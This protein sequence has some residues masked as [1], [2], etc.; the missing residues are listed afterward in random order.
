MVVLGVHCDPDQIDVS[1]TLV[2]DGAVAAAIEEERITRVKHARGFPVGA[3]RRC[4]EVA[5]LRG[6]DV[7]LVALAGDRRANL[8]A[9]SLWTLRHRP[10]PRHIVARLRAR[11]GGTGAQE[12]IA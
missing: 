11:R 3:I 7:D 10:S 2:V 8:L 9:R 4:L 1:A 12:A 6:T 5:G